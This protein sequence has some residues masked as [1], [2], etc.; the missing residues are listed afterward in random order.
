MFV[1]GKSMEQR[2]TLQIWL[3]IKTNRPEK[4]VLLGEA[5]IIP[6][7]TIVEL[8]RSVN[9]SFVEEWQTPL[10]NMVVAAKFF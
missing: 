1:N 10:K 9:L 3:F 2:Q 4:T 6:V 5:A 7:E 8:Q